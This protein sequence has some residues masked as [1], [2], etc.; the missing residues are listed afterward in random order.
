MAQ[1]AELG[2]AYV[3]IIPSA[4][5][6]S[7]SISSV[8]DPEATSAGKKAGINIA[9]GIGS[10]LKG[11]ATTIAAGAAVMTGAIVKGTADVAAYGDNIDK[12]SQKMG[13]S[14]QAYQ[15]WDAVLQHSGT[16]IEVMQ[17]GM[18]TLSKAA[19]NGADAFAAIGVSQ[20]EL[21]S[22]SQE[23]LFARTIEGLQGMEA[24]TERTV[25]AQKLLG[26]ASKELGAL[27]NTSAEDTQAMRD[28]VRELGGVMSDDA[29]KASAAFQDNMQD[30]KTAISG[31]GRGMMSELLPN[32][33]EIISGFTMLVAGEEGAEEKL[34]SGFQGLFANLGTMVRGFVDSIKEFLPTIVS[35]LTTML[36]EIIS[37]ATELIVSLSQAIVDVLPELITTVIPA[38]A[39]AALQ[40]I[41]ALG[42]ALLEAAPQLLDA[43]V[44]L[45]EMLGDSFRSSNML[46]TGA[47][48]IQGVLDG[49]TAALPGVSS[50]GVEI[51]TNVANGI[52]SAVPS[53]IST[54]GQLVTSLASF[55]MQ[56][57]PTLLNS[58]ADLLL[59]LVDGI[60]DN[61]PEIAHS[62]IEVI[63]NLAKTLAENYPA[64]IQAGFELIIKLVEGLVKAIPE[65][66]TAILEICADIVNEFMKVDWISLGGDIINGIIEGIVKLGDTLITAILDLCTG[67]FDA[68]KKFFGISSPSRLMAEEVG[69]YIPEGIAVGI[70]KYS[71]SVTD[72]M[73]DLEAD[74]MDAA[75]VMDINTST[76]FSGASS[77]T[78]ILARMDAI[79]TI[80]SKYFPELAEQRVNTGSN[81]G[82]G[83]IDRSLGSMMS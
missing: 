9:G 49:I 21:A 32:M 24:G 41:I 19:E 3:Q 62:A 67:A 71:G 37:L 6:I 40:I 47:Q 65:L 72:A 79:L 55:V 5:G 34:S 2:K 11:A 36:P 16:S 50:K 17:R 10:A 52:L 18:T 56:N 45:F 1:G 83:Y 35:G 12:M 60:I 8:L 70:E 59:N 38:L 74:V 29:V 68:V 4:Q 63:M 42:Q 43:G 76:N 27:L 22:L 13:M 7:G 73:D 64:I 77:E 28:R 78:A 46:D 61:L 82:I 53:L 48:V 26:G 20:E 44:Q 14:A 39:Q 66:L 33:N 69:R 31:L 57:A 15:E 54:A 30:L 25:L 80:L 58:G 23:D 75:A 81:F 51:L